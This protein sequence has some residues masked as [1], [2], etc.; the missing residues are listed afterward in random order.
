MALHFT[1]LTLYETTGI[2]SL[3]NDF[4]DFADQVEAFG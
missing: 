2:S 4:F 1:A 3:N